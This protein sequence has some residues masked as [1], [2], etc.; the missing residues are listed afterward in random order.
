[1]DF[2]TRGAGKAAIMRRPPALQTGDTVALISPASP[3]SRNG[4]SPDDGVSAVKSRLKRVGLRTVVMPYAANRNQSYGYLAARDGERASDLME[5]FADP[6]IDGILCVGGG[7]GTPRLLD[8]LDYEV[9]ARNP[10]VFIGYSDITALH[11]AIGQQTGLV[12]FHGPMGFELASFERSHSPL[13]QH[14]FTWDW[15]LRATMST[16]PLGMLPVKAPWQ[17]SPLECVVP[18]HARG[19][20]VGGNL[21]LISN[22]LGTP[23]EIDTKGKIVLIEE[24]GEAPY[25]IDRMLTQLR[26]A[27]KIEAAAGLIFAEWTQCDSPDPARPSLTLRQVLADIIEPLQIPTIYGL[28]AG[29]GPGRITLPLGTLVSLDASACR[30]TVEESGVE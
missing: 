24:V 3:F 19:R 10:K 4:T 5:A 21:S 18:G 17:N 28:A 16:Q 9:I 11:L 30:I 15:F 27:G 25:R 7:Y 6:K 29:H 14:E 26:L 20:L 23:Y 12:T 1:M 22:T 8:R 2:T 13:P